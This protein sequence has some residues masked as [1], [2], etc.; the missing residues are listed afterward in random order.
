MYTYRILLYLLVSNIYLIIVVFMVVTDL[1]NSILLG[2]PW[3][4]HKRDSRAQPSAAFATISLPAPR[5][6]CVCAYKFEL[7]L[8]FLKAYFLAKSNRDF[9]PVFHRGC[10]SVL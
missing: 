5:N 1:F 6:R 10:L 8:V 9:F 7:E 2:S 3:A 4:T